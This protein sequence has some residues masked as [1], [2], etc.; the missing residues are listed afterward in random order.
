MSNVRKIWVT[1]DAEKHILYMARV[2]SPKQ[3]SGDT[4]LINY[5]IKHKHWSPFEMANM[6]VEVITGRDISTQILRHKSFNFQEFSQ[7]YA[8]SAGMDDITLRKQD[9]KNRQNSLDVLNNEAKEY[10]ETKINLTMQMVW[11]L[12]NE[13]LANDI[14]KE[15]ARRILPMATTTKIYISG[16]LRSWIHYLEARCDIAT[17]LEHREIANKIKE[18]FI[19][20]FPIIS[21]ALGYEG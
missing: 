21:K 14:A 8:Q 18:I 19:S 7:R 6:C 1:P 20:E 16:N 3:D 10:W 13:M 15:C 12:Y 5:L 11:N 2:S 4:K 17:Q 9:H